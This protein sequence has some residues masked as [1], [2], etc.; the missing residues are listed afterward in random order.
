MAIILDFLAAAFLWVSI[1]FTAVVFGGS[2][3]ET[4]VINSVWWSDLPGSLA[5]MTN[6]QHSVQPGRF[7][8]QLA[9]FP[10]IAALLSMLFNLRVSGRRALTAAAFVCMLIVAV[11]T[12]FYF[13]PILMI[14]FSP[15]GGGKSAEELT[16]L[17]INWK[18]GTWLRMALILIALIL[19]II[20]LTV[21]NDSASSGRIYRSF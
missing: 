16:Q 8:G 21:K 12:I 15:D 20:G 6:T 5:F 2:V 10:T 1:V 19:S 3:Y 18:N 9:G 11:T 13:V 14:I 7:W 17:A 4:L